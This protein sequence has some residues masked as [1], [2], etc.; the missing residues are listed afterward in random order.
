MNGLAAWLP[1]V[2]VVVVIIIAATIAHAV[3]QRGMARRKIPLQND[4]AGFIFSVVG[5]LYAVVLGFVVI[6]AW[7]KYDQA[8]NYVDGEVAAAADLYHAVT[9]MPP[10]LRAVVEPKLRAY[11]HRMATADWQDMSRQTFMNGDIETLEQISSAVYHHEPRNAGDQ[12]VHAQA[13]DQLTLLFD[14]RRQ[15]LSE[16]DPA[17]PAILWFAL[18]AGA[19][20]TI[21]CA[22]LFAMENRGAQL[23]MTALLAGLIGVLFVVIWEFDLPFSGAVA[24][25]PQGWQ[26]LDA[27]LNHIQ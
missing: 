1:N 23:L 9:A 4:V 21:G 17:V 20:A 8:Q 10:D 3:V 26:R 13:L 15:R 18:I 14:A 25:A 16:G 19:V 5:V 7:Q 22:F 27:R 12:D 11:V 2:G 24:V 6:I